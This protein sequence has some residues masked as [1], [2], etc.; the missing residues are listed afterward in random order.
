MRDKGTITG[1]SDD[2]F[3]PAISITSLRQRD[4]KYEVE[5]VA[6]SRSSVLHLF[7]CHLRNYPIHI[8]TNALLLKSGLV[9]NLGERISKVLRINL[10]FQSAEWIIIC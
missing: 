3:S 1:S 7:D 5:D 4:L 8:C 6:V 9:R 2:D 10:R